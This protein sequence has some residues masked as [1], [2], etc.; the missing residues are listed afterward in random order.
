MN[1]HELFTHDISKEDC[2]EVVVFISDDPERFGVLAGIFFDAE[3]RIS[4]RA[5]WP[6]SYCVI[7]HPPLI[8]PYFPRLFDMLETPNLHNAI[9]RNILRLLQFVQTPEKYHGKL[10]HIC[11]ELVGSNKTAV[12]IKAFAI[13][14]L[15]NLSIHYPD[16]IPELRLLVENRWDHETAAFRS[17]A[18]KLR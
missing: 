11:F 2:D 15:Q 5:A 8:N 4:R 14:I 1:L 18:R 3:S 7:H 13:T 16:I 12:A 17:R 6:M 10:M 9:I